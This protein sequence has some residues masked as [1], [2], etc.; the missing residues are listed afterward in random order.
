MHA[1]LTCSHAILKV[2][3]MA[4]P[5]AMSYAT[6]AGLQP[7]Y[8]TSPEPLYQPVITVVFS[9]KAFTMLLLESFHTLFLEHLLR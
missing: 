3:V 4:V 5:Q 2:G 1:H 7:V 9:P 8:G 6:I